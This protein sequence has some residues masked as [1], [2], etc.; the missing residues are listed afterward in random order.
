MANTVTKIEKYGLAT[1]V[2]E[3][4]RGG[5]LTAARIA[6]VLRSENPALAISESAVA[7]YVGGI[8]EGLRPVAQQILE[9]HVQEVLPDDLKALEEMEAQCL[10]WSRENAQ[11][12]IERAA[13]AAVRIAGEVD[14]WAGLVR[15]ASL[16]EVKRGLVIKSIVKQCLTYL[17]RE[18]RFQEKRIAAMAMAHKVIET[19]LRHSGLLDEDTKGKIV[20]LDRSAEYEEPAAAGSGQV[21][22]ATSEVH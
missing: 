11:D 18:D 20:I 16:D 10:A 6:E 17:A 5:V 22:F 19:K 8:K 14:L 21:S 12:I 13:A 2:V 7:R 15:E 9:A 3:L 1:R 4:L